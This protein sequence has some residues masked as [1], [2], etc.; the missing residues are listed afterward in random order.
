MNTKAQIWF[1]L[2]GP[3]FMLTFL[4]AWALLGGFLP[5]TPPL[6]TAAEIVAFYQAHPVSMRLGLMLCELGMAFLVFFGAVLSIQIWRIERSN[7]S[8]YPIWAAAHLSAWAGTI[9]GLAITIVV[10]ETAA[11]RLDRDP[12]I[13]L[14]IHDFG[15]V[16]MAD[17][18]APFLVVPITM[19]M[20]GLKDKRKSPLFPRWACYYF[21]MSELAILPG[22]MIIFFQSGPF[23][24]NG[25][26]GWWIPVIDWGLWFTT[27]TVL[28]IRGIKR[29]ARE[30]PDTY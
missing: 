5:P 14:A 17:M 2:C 24:W 25:L 22:A 28:L 23:A 21:L 10:W 27:T 16:M 12:D 1:A 8:R 13:L 7:G 4:L 30:E 9:C 18:E 11:Y 26:F 3:A 19:A 15:W 20:V 6:S 29:Q